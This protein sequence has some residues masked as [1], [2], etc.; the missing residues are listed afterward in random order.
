MILNIKGTMYDKNRHEGFILEEGVIISSYDTGQHGAGKPKIKIEYQDNE[1]K[2]YVATMWQ[3]W[4]DD[5]GDKIEFYIMENEKEYAWWNGM[6]L[7]KFGF[8]DYIVF[9]IIC[10][11][12]FS[13]ITGKYITIEEEV[14]INNKKTISAEVILVD[15][16]HSPKKLICQEKRA[17]GTVVQYKKEKEWGNFKEKPGEYVAVD[18]NA[19]NERQYEIFER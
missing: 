13:Q 4:N 9:F 10:N 1:G 5:V 17:D 3:R 18:V 8:L 16:L 7:A 6:N 19:K 15:N 12:I 14:V 11:I 2:I